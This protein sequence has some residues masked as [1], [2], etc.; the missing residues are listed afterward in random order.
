MIS[1]SEVTGNL[2]LYSYLEDR[3]SWELPAD[4]QYDAA[5]P[6]KPETAGAPFE[7]S[8]A[9][10]ADRLRFTVPA[11]SAHINQLEMNQMALDFRSRP[12]ALSHRHV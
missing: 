5:N 11:G 12:H 6:W 7:G 1:A 4:A 3:V 2:D 8:I 10:G 9:Y